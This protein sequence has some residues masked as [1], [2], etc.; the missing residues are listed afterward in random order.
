MSCFD[1]RMKQLLI[2][3]MPQRLRLARLHRKIGIPVNYGRRGL[4]L[5]REAKALVAVPC[6]LNGN[7]LQMTRSTRDAWLEMQAAAQAEGVTL[8]VEWAYRS[9]SRQALLFSTFS[10]RE[11]LSAAL[12][13]VAAPGYSEHHTGCALDIGSG[14]CFPCSPAFENTA[15]FAWLRD[16]AGE[17][18]FSMTYPRNNQ[19]GFMYEPWHWF[20]SRG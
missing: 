20:C 15:A 5:H 9:F 16:R 19:Y 4:P 6:G 17:F 14:D 13:R 8:I 7:P 2:R 3:F 12:A 18:D 11:G 10:N 1:E